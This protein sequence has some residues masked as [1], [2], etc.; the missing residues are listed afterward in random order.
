MARQEA[1]LLEIA[2]ELSRELHPARKIRALTMASSI[3]RDAGLDSLARIELLLRVEQKLG[4]R[5]PD[6]AVLSAETFSDLLAVAQ[7]ILPEARGIAAR[8]A[9]GNPPRRL[10]WSSDRTIDRSRSTPACVRARAQG[11]LRQ[12]TV[13]R[14]PREQDRCAGAPLV[15]QTRFDGQRLRRVPHALLAASRRRPKPSIRPL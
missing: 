15:S 7:H 8:E 4:L 3:E 9:V 11:P 2:R 13:Y 14:L 5:L 6:Q 10:R 1:V 12:W